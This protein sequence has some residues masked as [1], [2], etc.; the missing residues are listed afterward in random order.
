MDECLLFR[1]PT[2]HPGDVSALVALLDDG[3]LQP[4]EIVAI[5]GKT[6][7]NGCVNDFTRPFAVMALQQLLAERLGCPQAVVHDR[8]AMV[9]SGGT[10]GGI[11]PHILVLARRALPDGAGVEHGQG[12]GQGEG[13]MAVGVA[14][15]QHFP[16]AELGRLPQVDATAEAV[17]RAMRDAGIDDP[18]DVHFV[19]IKCPLL[20][21]ERVAGALQRG[22]TVAT[23]DTYE[24]MGFSRGASAL[25]V[26]VALGEVDR[27]QLQPE[28][29]GKDF[30]F[31]SGRASASAGIELMRNEVIVLGNSHAWGGDL[32][33]GHGVMQDV[34]DLPAVLGVLRGLGMNTEGQLSRREAARVVAV[35][36]KADPPRTGNIRGRRHIMWD[37]S[38]INA[39]RHARAVVGGVVGA[40]VGFTD[41]F[42]SGGA[43]HQG[44]DGG[45]P[46]AVVVDLRPAAS[47][48]G[49]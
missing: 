10:E 44:P 46:I 23:H 12:Q 29:I 1:L 27:A 43:E 2:S 5:F 8:V 31:W 37:D 19:Q 15:T 38:D 4:D 9:M 21:S 28:H 42:V 16:P 33:I 22:D 24:S 7:G 20:T 32:R 17:R 36:V 39:T 49:I 3:T 18:A 11:S 40:A 35:L 34:I 14:F 30:S 26:A 48:N 25:G 13:R 45:G 6:E 41:V 47:S